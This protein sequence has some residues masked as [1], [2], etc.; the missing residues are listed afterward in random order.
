MAKNRHGEPGTVML[1]WRP[2]FTVFRNLAVRDDE[3]GY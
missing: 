1:E 2:E 3:D